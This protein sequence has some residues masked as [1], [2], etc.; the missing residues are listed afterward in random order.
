MSTL[1]TELAQEGEKHKGTDLGRLLQ[2]AAL[3]IAE[4]DEALAEVRAEHEAEEVQRINMEQAIFEA[5]QKLVDISE[6]LD[7]SRP[8]NIELARDHAPH[9]N[10]MA[11]E[12]VAP[13][14]KKPRKSSKDKP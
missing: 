14:A 7:Y 13:Y 11:A 3:H 8:V 5:R 2:W 1:T 9:I 6:M 10:R 12:G 4:Q